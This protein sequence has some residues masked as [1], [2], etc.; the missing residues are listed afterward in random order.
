LLRS[1]GMSE[2]EC[3]V[4][5][6]LLEKPKGESIDN[7]LTSFGPAPQEA[8]VA[9]RSLIEN[10]CIS[11]SSNRIEAKPPRD[12]LPNILRKKTLDF[13]LELRQA[14]EAIRYLELSLEPY[15][16]ERRTGLRPEEI[17]RPLTELD[18]M[19]AQTIE[20]IT[21]ARSY[22]YVFA[23]KFDWY[24]NIRH[25]LKDALNRGVKTNVLMLVKDQ[26]TTKRS[27]E[28]RQ[29]G[30]EV[31]HCTEEWYPV[32]GTLIDDERLVFL[33]WAT[34]K[35]GITQPIYYKPHYTENAGLIRI[36]KDAFQKRWE[37]AKAI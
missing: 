7:I 33:I 16:W 2:D 37:E 32:R 12:F 11:I 6:D 31:R 26:Y 14:Q 4:Y 18:S 22:I 30:V 17:I 20:M 15:Y 13:D 29:L 36:F 28:L 24:E 34:K 25:Q 19:E 35:S 8:E 5:L 1:L 9:V 3:A 27:K 21:N 10:G 23:E